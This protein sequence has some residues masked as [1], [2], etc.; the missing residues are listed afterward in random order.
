MSITTNTHKK[1]T[2]SE[3][4]TCWLPIILWG[5]IIVFITSSIDYFTNWWRVFAL[6]T[7]FLPVSAFILKKANKSKIALSFA[8]ALTAV[9]AIE[10]IYYLVSCH[11]YISK[12]VLNDFLHFICSVLLVLFIALPDTKIKS[13]FFVFPLFI[14]CFLEL[15]FS[16]GD[17]MLESCYFLGFL[18]TNTFYCSPKQYDNKKSLTALARLENLARLKEQGVLTDEDFRTKKAEIMEQM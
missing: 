12:Y 18:T 16:S 2:C 15:A 11:F 6:F 14:I 3:F 13:F 17:F 9:Y 10:I 8:V 5:I 7:T 4:I 1:Q